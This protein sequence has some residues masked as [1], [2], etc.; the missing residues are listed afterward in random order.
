[1]SNFDESKVARQPGGSS[2]G[3]EFASKDASRTDAGRVDVFAHRS[4]ADQ[5]MA[6]V[7]KW[8]TSYH[9]DYDEKDFREYYRD[10]AN[11]LLDSG[12]D[13]PLLERWEDA[14]FDARHEAIEEQ[15]QN[16]ATEA[17][18]EYESLTVEQRDELHDR[19]AEMDGNYKA[20]YERLRGSTG[21]F[22]VPAGNIDWDGHN[23]A[24]EAVEAKARQ[25]GA[26]TLHPKVRDAIRR[27]SAVHGSEWSERQV[28]AEVH[29]NGRLSEAGEAVRNNEPRNINAVLHIDGTDIPIGHIEHTFEEGEVSVVDGQ[30]AWE[31]NP[32]PRDSD[33]DP[34]TDR[35]GFDVGEVE[36]FG[37]NSVTYSD[38]RTITTEGNMAIETHQRFPGH[39]TKATVYGDGSVARHTVNRAENFTL[40][41]KFTRHPD[42]TFTKER[43]EFSKEGDIRRY[44]RESLDSN[45]VLTVESGDAAKTFNSVTF[46]DGSMESTEESSV[47]KRTINRNGTRY[48]ERTT[49]NQSKMERTK[50]VEIHGDDL[51]AQW[52][53]DR[54]DGSME[55]LRRPSGSI[56]GRVTYPSGNRR[57]INTWSDPTDSGIDL[58]LDLM[59]E[60][61]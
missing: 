15:I 56:T 43:T 29:W 25:L 30:A 34:M 61:R 55:L 60:T 50:R 1:M 52:S 27:A 6:H 10:E 9:N 23:T 31:D 18:I 22:G 2:E 16:A 53:T 38:G 21:V 42:G 13:I 40:D 39:V 36:E 11:E 41:T 57:D 26:N 35:Y 48:F 19:I 20:F 4:T 59:K 24:F 58:A 7:P 3:G 28:P 45:G 5:V 33:I 17:G 47:G 8:F 14:T 46:P 51:T 32:A 54:G 37:T 49:M 44:S 12:N